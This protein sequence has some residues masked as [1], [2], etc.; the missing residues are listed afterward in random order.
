ME[1]SNQ[2]HES[3]RQGLTAGY[4]FA[5]TFVIVFYMSYCLPAQLVKNNSKSKMSGNKKTTQKR[6]LPYQELK[7]EKS[8]EKQKRAR[9][10]EK[11][12]PAEL[13][14]R[15]IQIDEIGWLT[16]RT[17]FT[18][19]CEATHHFSEGSAIGEG[20]TGT[21]YKATLPNGLCLAVKRL[22]DSELFMRRFKIERMMG[23][24][25]HRNIITPINFCVEKERNERILVYD[26][27]SNGRLSDWLNDT[28]TLGWSAVIRIALGVARGLSCLHHSLHMV[29][30]SI[31]PDSILLGNNFE[32]KISNFGGAIFISYDLGS[33][34]DKKDVFD[35]GTLLFELIRGKTFH[36][37]RK[38]FSNSNGPFETYTYATNML[39]DPSDFYDAVDK[40]L[41]DIDFEDEV[42][43]LLRV[44]CDC[45]HPFPFKRPTMLEVYSKM[46]KIWDIDGN[47]E[48]SLM[49]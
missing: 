25:S 43:A 15:R 30:L 17:S 31:G 14:E 9:Q 16:C 39:E 40:S 33:G 1:S 19:L 20:R 41:K 18:E 49:S 23:R 29:H 37:T 36:Q 5:A 7:Q 21:M 13:I 24:Y 34:F 4:V 38:C 47:F 26:Y 8:Q 45:V 11:E 44:A 46:S 48:D 32:P 2:F 3:F 6:R 12:L 42:S 10:R 35:F 22:Y 27:M 28:T